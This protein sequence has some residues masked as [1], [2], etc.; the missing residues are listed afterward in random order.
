MNEVQRHTG[1]MQVSRRAGRQLQSISDS[2]LVRIADV[3]AEAD[4]QTARV[5]AV[6]SVGAAAMQ[7]VSLV[8]QLA[9][10]AELMCPNAASEINLIRSAVAMSASQIVMETTNRT[11]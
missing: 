5:A 4:V 9:Q 6:T 1:G 2:T 3:A 11:R 7:S 10:S 8:A